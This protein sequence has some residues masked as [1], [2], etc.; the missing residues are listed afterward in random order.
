MHKTSLT[1]GLAAYFKAYPTVKF[2]NKTIIT[3]Q[4]F[5]PL[6]EIPTTEASK[7]THI[8]P[9][10]RHFLLLFFE[11]QIFCFAKSSTIIFIIFLLFGWT[12]VVDNN[13]APGICLQIIVKFC[14][15]DQVP[16]NYTVYPNYFGHFSQLEAEEE[17]E[18]YEAIVDVQCYEL[19][20][21]FLCTLFVP[22][23]G[24]AGLIPPCRSLCTGKFNDKQLNMG[25][26]FVSVICNRI[27]RMSK[28]EETTNPFFDLV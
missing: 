27:M 19:A 21:L 2:V 16:Y 17:L 11:W 15:S 9:Y 20:S 24:A 26:A 10:G 14:Q 1:G 8:I 23:C 6:A 25:G 12:I 7:K 18:P 13:P 4:R 3:P 28:H 5:L 22:K